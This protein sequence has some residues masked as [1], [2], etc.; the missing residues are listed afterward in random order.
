M[1]KGIEYLESTPIT[2]EHLTAPQCPK[3]I[4]PPSNSAEI[5]ESIKNKIEPNF[6]EGWDGYAV[7]DNQVFA[8]RSI[9]RGQRPTEYVYRELG[10]I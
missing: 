1:N 5:R 9:V 8:V 2:G 10:L 6:P 7:A 3:S 4:V